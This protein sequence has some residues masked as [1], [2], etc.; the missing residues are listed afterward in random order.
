MTCNKLTTNETFCGKQTNASHRKVKRQSTEMSLS[1]EQAVKF[2]GCIAIVLTIA[3]NIVV[4]NISRK[5][6]SLCLQ[7]Q[8]IYTRESNRT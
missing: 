2:L 7:N 4:R 5:E 6:Q 8:Q 3:Y 1:D